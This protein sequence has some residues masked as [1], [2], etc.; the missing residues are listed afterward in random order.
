MAHLYRDMSVKSLYTDRKCASKD[1]WQRAIEESTTLYIGNLSFFTTEEQLY[2]F[3]GRAGEVKRIIMG[4]DRHQKTPCGF[5]FVE[6]HYR[7]DTE[8]AMRFLGGCKLDDRI[9]RV[10][11]DGGFVEGRQYG[12]GRSGGQVREEYRTD[13]DAQRGGWGRGDDSPL[14]GLEPIQQRRRSL[15]GGKGGGKGGGGGYHGGGQHGGGYLGGGGGGGRDVGGKR[16]ASPEP[17]AK[18]SRGEAANPRF[19]EDKDEDDEED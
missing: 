2:E 5:C 15:D 13:F 4:L 17:S 6:Y 16:G 7:A 9:V 3:F 18:R 19:R 12:R 1:Q 11:W 14:P 8:D 10:D